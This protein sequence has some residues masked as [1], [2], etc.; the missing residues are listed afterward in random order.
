M[1]LRYFWKEATEPE[2]FTQLYEE[3]EALIGRP[4]PFKM[5][6]IIK[7]PESGLS[8]FMDYLLPWLIFPS[9]YRYSPSIGCITYPSP[10]C[11]TID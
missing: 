11:S 3:M 9:L 10:H 2:K 8:E 1:V 7:F 4:C 6:Q 5:G